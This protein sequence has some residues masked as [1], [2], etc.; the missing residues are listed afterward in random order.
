MKTISLKLPAALNVRLERAAR[1]L[2]RVC[3][4]RNTVEA[5]LR[6]FPRR[7]GVLGPAFRPGMRMP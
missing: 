2:G 4:C 5:R 1:R 7:A 3:E 6:A